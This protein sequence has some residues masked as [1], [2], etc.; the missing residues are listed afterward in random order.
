MTKLKITGSALSISEREPLISGAGNTIK[1]SLDFSP[2]WHGLVKQITFKNLKS[3]VSRRISADVE[4]CTVPWEVLDSE[5]DVD[6][7]LR[8]LDAKGALVMRTN[9]ENLGTV[10]GADDD[11]AAEASAATPEVLDELAA[12]VA[13]LEK[14]IDKLGMPVTVRL[15][16]DGEGV[17]TA[18]KSF[19]ELQAALADGREIVLTANGETRA[20]VCAYNENI[21]IFST[22][23]S[24]LKEN[25]LVSYYILDDGRWGGETYELAKKT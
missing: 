14:R 13:A 5:G 16:D 10:I 22:V 6:C 2:E 24:V 21:V 1:I 19:E 8:G 9:E 23:F 15:T 7:S 18:D 11:D 12:A 20:V 17:I 4:P 25:R 3:G